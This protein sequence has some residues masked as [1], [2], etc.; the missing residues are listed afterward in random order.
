MAQ[1]DRF[2]GHKGPLSRRRCE[3]V[4]RGSDSAAGLLLSTAALAARR[5]DR[6]AFPRH[7]GVLGD[8]QAGACQDGRSGPTESRERRLPEQ[9]EGL[10]F[11]VLVEQIWL[12]HPHT[13]AVGGYARSAVT[14]GASVSCCT[15]NVNVKVEPTPSWLATQIRPP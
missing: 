1:E 6:E 13:R 10:T 4:G 12:A 7:A 3:R 11:A 14:P 15:G 5:N 9:G 2:V 8:A